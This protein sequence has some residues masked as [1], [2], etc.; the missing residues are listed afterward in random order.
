MA[1][2][3]LAFLNLLLLLGTLADRR[4]TEAGERPEERRYDV[5]HRARETIDMLIAL[6]KRASGRLSAEESRV[7]DTLLRDLQARYVRTL[8]R[9]RPGG[10]AAAA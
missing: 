9:L 5:L 6:R 1:D 2:D 10:G 8:H 3:E 7:L 4:M